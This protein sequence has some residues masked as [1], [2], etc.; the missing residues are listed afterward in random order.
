MMAYKSQELLP[1]TVQ[2]AIQGMALRLNPEVA[3]DLQ[4]T[5]QFNITPSNSPRQAATTS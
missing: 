5:I 3:G 1:K 4:A 2:E